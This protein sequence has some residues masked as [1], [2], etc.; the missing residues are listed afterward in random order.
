MAYR[1]FPESTAAK[2]KSASPAGDGGAGDGAESGASNEA[3]MIAH[4]LKG[5]HW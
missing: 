5:V 1:V 3:L 4:L 2:G